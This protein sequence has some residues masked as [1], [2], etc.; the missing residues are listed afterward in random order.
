MKTRVSLKCRSLK[1]VALM[2][3][4]V[5]MMI[6][7]WWLALHIQDQEVTVHHHKIQ[8]VKWCLIQEVDKIMAHAHLTTNGAAP[9][10]TCLRVAITLTRQRNTSSVKKLDRKE[11]AFLLIFWTTSGCTNSTTSALV[12]LTLTTIA[13][14]TLPTTTTHAWGIHSTTTALRTTWLMP[15]GGSTLTPML[16]RRHTT[17]APASRTS[18]RLAGLNS[19]Q[20]YSMV[21]V[22][23]HA[24]TATNEW[25]LKQEV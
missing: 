4:L 17:T 9:T 2:I 13:S 22:S 14:A 20:V 23:C 5:S 3:S 15:T 6:K 8:E 10:T 25:L 11:S 7:I 16:L 18:R 21:L 19:K 1:W 24:T 12:L